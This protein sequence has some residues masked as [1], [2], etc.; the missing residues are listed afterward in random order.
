MCSEKVSEEAS[1]FQKY[2]PVFCRIWLDLIGNN[3][4]KGRGSVSD[5][6]KEAFS[7]QL[8]AIVTGSLKFLYTHFNAFSSLSDTPNKNEKNP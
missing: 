5:L 8:C 4:D 1:S 2:S 7:S 3:T 6:A